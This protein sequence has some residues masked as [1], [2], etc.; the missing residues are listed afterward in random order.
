MKTR[1]IIVRHAQAEGNI[2][3]EFHGWTDSGLTE[4]GHIQAEKVADRLKEIPIDILYS[5]SLTRTLQTAEYI[6]KVKTLP[7]IRTDKLKEINGGDWEGVLFSEL[8]NLWPDEY[9]TWENKP[10]SHKMPNGESMDEFQRRLI[11]EVEYIIN[12]NTGKNIGIVTH[13]TAIKAMMCFFK[14][15]GLCEMSNIPWCDNT[16]VTILDYEEGKYTPVLEGDASHLDKEF[17]TVQNQEWWEDY[18]TKLKQKKDK[19]IE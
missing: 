1:L 10:Q 4:L 2:S 7:I 3:R 8:P 6:S 15:F 11:E 12:H 5:S 13:G 14:G 19:N 18:I 16:A 17:S 9:E